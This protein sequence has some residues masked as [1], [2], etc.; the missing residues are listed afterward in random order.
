[1]LFTE[2]PNMSAPNSELVKVEQQ[3]PPTGDN[4]GGGGGNFGSGGP[5]SGGNGSSGPPAKVP[6]M[7]GFQTTKSNGA[8]TTY[9]PT[10]NDTCFNLFTWKTVTS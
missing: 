2:V 9:K 4:N 6:R 5:S 10:Q 3:K 8:G 7:D 1:M